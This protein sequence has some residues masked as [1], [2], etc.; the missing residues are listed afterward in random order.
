VAVDVDND[1]EIRGLRAALI[2]GKGKAVTHDRTKKIL[3]D[4]ISELRESTYLPIVAASVFAGATVVI[5][6]LSATKSWIIFIPIFVVLALLL[7]VLRVSRKINRL[8]LEIE[9]IMA[10]R[11]SDL[12]EHDRAIKRLIEL[13]IYGRV[14]PESVV[15]CCCQSRRYSNLVLR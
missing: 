3:I 15:N 11:A 2:I 12:A 8:S 13:G 5:A 9:R 6:G 1:P 10:R 7:V 14:A 4:Q